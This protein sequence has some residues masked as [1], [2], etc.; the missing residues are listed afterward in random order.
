MLCIFKE[1]R[2]PDNS[3]ECHWILT[4]CFRPEICKLTLGRLL[5]I[6]KKLIK[7]LGLNKNISCTEVNICNLPGCD[8]GRPQGFQGGFKIKSWEGF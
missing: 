1:K 3:N 7:K 2:S 8:A 5:F 6:C 4:Y